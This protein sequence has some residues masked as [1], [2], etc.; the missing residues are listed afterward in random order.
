MS[1]ILVIARRE[2]L[3]TVVTRGFVLSLVMVPIL[4][5]GL[6]TPTAVQSTRSRRNA[7]TKCIVEPATATDSR[8]GNDF[9][10]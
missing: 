7:S 6:G 5:V 2:Y 8:R 4:V 3:A 9:W 10:R 1:K